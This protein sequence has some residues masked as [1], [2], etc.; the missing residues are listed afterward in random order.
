MERG[1]RDEAIGRVH[2]RRELPIVRD[3]P[4]S[5]EVR[6]EFGYAIGKVSR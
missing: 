3:L 5:V 2:Y 6:F 4:E 1:S